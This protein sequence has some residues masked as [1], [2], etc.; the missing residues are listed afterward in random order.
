MSDCDDVNPN[1]KDICECTR[2][3]M[4]LAQCNNRRLLWGKP[5]LESLGGLPP[6]M[7]VAAPLTTAQ[8]VKSFVSITA[9]TVWRVVRLQ[10]G[11]LT[12]EEMQPRIDTCLRCEHLSATGHCGLCGCSCQKENTVRFLNKLAHRGSECFDNPPRWG[13]ME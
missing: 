13:K 2:A 12:D 10:P 3:G 1:V 6:E 4:T 11:L 8:R 9:Q 5:P 7:P